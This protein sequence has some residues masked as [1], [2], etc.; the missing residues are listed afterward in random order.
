MIVGSDDGIVYAL[1]GDGTAVNGWPQA[2]GGFVRCS[3]AVVDLD[4]NGF[5]DVVVGSFDQRVH[6][7]SGNGTAL[8]GFPRLMGTDLESSP[9]V[10]DID[11]DGLSEVV[12]AGRN[13]KVYALNSDGTS[14][15]GAGFP[16]VTTDDIRCTPFLADIDADGAI[17]I[18][19]G[20][21]DGKIYSFNLPEGSFNPLNIQWPMFGRDAQHSKIAGPFTD[22][23]GSSGRP[24][25]DPITI[26]SLAGGQGQDVSVH[27]TR[28]GPSENTP[29]T[30]RWT[31]MT[32]VIETD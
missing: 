23:A 32:P 26:P 6:A 21:D 15:S 14:V 4:G 19:T 16:F 5:L 2:T 1:N 7:W 31:P 8:T 28:P 25:G 12:I 17:E 10:A 29:T 18:V 20:S 27:G 9:V 11:G 30:F 13:G 24:I 22:R 3:P